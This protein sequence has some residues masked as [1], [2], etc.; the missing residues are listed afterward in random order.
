LG[1]G[2]LSPVCSSR[3]SLVACCVGCSSLL[4]LSSPLSIY[5]KESAKGLRCEDLPFNHTPTQKNHKQK[6]VI[7]A[8]STD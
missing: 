5:I 7:K 6:Q 2:W 8:L 1:V 3:S 4:L